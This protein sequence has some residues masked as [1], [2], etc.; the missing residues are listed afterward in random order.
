[1]GSQIAG[2]LIYRDRMQRFCLTALLFL[3]ACGPGDPHRSTMPN[4]PNQQS[5]GGK[6]DMVCDEDDSVNMRAT[7]HLNNC[8]PR[9]EVE[10]DKRAMQDRIN[11]ANES[12]QSR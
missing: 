2:G 9:S 11:Y 12:Q 10:A 4:Q 1:M 3:S 6:D 5:K 8:R 7:S